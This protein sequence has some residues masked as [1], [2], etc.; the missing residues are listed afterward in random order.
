MKPSSN[1]CRSNSEGPSATS[2]L[3][4]CLHWPRS[5]I[6]KA[7]MQLKVGKSP[8][9]DGIPQRSIS[10]EEKQCS[11]SS[12]I[13]SPI[14]GRKGLYRRTPGMQ[15]LSLYTETMEKIRLFKL[16]RHHCALHCRQNLARVLLNRL[17]PTIAQENTPESQCGFRS[18]RGTTDMIFVLRYI[19]EKCIEQNTG[20]Y[21]AFVDRTKAFDTVSCDRL[22]KPSASSMKVSKIR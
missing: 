16:P 3:C 18:N 19:Q 2:A 10:T 17:I 22:W 9:I 11:I 13:C 15:S 7:T 8:G 1:A 4:Y 12:R 20:L 6:K 5:E 21:A 14:V